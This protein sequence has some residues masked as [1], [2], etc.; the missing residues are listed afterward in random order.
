MGAKKRNKNGYGCYEKCDLMS[1]KISSN[2]GQH[3]FEI[4][5][6]FTDMFND[7]ELPNCY[8]CIYPDPFLNG[9]QYIGLA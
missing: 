8:T 6:M 4:L 5:I 2:N 9:L 3:L 1:H 7:E